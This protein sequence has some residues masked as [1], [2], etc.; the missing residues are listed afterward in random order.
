[1]KQV[2]SAVPRAA[3]RGAAIG[4]SFMALFGTL[5]AGIGIAGLQDWGSFWL[6]IG[7]ALIGITLLAG[8][9]SLMLRS[10]QL[11][12]Q[13]TDAD[14]KHWKR[15]SIWFGIIFTIEGAAIGAASAICSATDH[16]DYLFP[17]MAIIVG[18]HFIPLAPLFRI[19]THYLTGTLLC[20]LAIY[21]LLFVP[22]RSTL[23]EQPIIAWW[24]VVGFGSTLILWG[25]GLAIW[26]L[27]EKWMKKN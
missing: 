14:A 8:G 21:T 6:W 25:T 10:K 18:A 1:M 5:W 13:V 2:S 3:V 24:C 27:G 26:L 12:V 20:L 17:I 23:G 22:V 16:I 19:K 9:I 11:T 7:A 15:A 4:V